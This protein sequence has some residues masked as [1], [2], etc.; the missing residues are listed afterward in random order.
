MHI[1]HSNAPQSHSSWFV[2][3]PPHSPMHTYFSLSDTEHIHRTYH[4]QTWCCI[5]YIIKMGSCSVF[6]W[7]PHRNLSSDQL[8]SLYRNL[9]PW[10]K[11]LSWRCI[12]CISNQWNHLVLSFLPLYHMGPRHCG[13]LWFSS[14]IH[15]PYQSISVL[16]SHFWPHFQYLT[17]WPYLTQ[18][19]SFVCQSPNFTIMLMAWHFFVQWGI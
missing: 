6:E 18:Q 19:Y 5:P 16:H 3:K 2:P 1:H 15:G 7:Y 12:N 8:P 14:I 4:L 13:C 17:L 9:I 10:E 11:L